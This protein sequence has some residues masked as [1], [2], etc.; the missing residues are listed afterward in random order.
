[1]IFV[2][3]S[4]ALADQIEFHAINVGQGDSMF[5]ILPGGEVVLIDGGPADA[6]ERVVNYLKNCKVKKIDLLIATHPHEDHIGGLLSVLDSFSVAKVWD[7]GFNLGTSTQRGFLERVKKSKAKFE[8]AREGLS[9]VIGD[10]KIQV[11]A[12]GNSSQKNSDANTNSI[13][14]HVS[15]KKISFLLM[16]DAEHRDSKTINKYPRSTVLKIA[17]HGSRY[18]TTK[19]LLQK[20]QPRAAVVSCGENNPYGHPHD[21]VLKLLEEFKVMLFST[22][23][24]NIVLISDGEKFSVNYTKSDEQSITSVIKSVLDIFFKW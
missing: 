16:G 17:H 21:E 12:A 23:D 4:A 11:I 19:P 10:V 20:V 22:I 15:W 14:T 18:G 24:G 5:F 3:A 9:Q 6:G 1:M 7:A 8:I 2:F 13:V